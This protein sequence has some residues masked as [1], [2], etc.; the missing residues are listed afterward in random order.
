MHLRHDVLAIEN[1][2]FALRRTQRDVQ[3]RAI[4]GD[5]DPLA[6]EH[7]VAA[8]RQARFVGQLPQQAH[9]FFADAVL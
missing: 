2:L 1:D 5:V 7:G 8:R 9:R 3:D 4:L 6:A